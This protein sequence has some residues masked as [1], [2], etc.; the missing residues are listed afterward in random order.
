M[1]SIIVTCFGMGP[2]KPCYGSLECDFSFYFCLC[3]SLEKIVT[4]IRFSVFWRGFALVPHLA[5]HPDENPGYALV[6]IAKFTYG[7]SSLQ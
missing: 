1:G 2:P 3:K 6:G 5:M 7:F 4:Q